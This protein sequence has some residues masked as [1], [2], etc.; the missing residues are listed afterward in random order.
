MLRWFRLSLAFLWTLVFFALC[1]LIALFRPFHHN[2][3]FLASRILT[4]VGLPILGIKVQKMPSQKTPDIHSSVIIL[5]H[6]HLIDIFVIGAVLPPYTVMIGKKELSYVPFLGLAF[7]LTGNIFINRTNKTKALA[8]IKK[9]KQL[10]NQQGQN[11]LIMP[12]GTRSNGRGLLPFKKG[13]FHLA[14]QTQAPIQP[15]VTSDYYGRLDFNAWSAGTIKFTM[16]D[17]IPTQGLT[18]QDVP[19]IR[20]L[21]YQRMQ[22]KITQFKES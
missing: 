5:N 3:S 15:I 21:A 16:I 20:E 22:A 8:S 19:R 14:I 1:P 7:R 9:A 12:E 13:P 6:Q 18:A 4:C 17:V 2:N 10:L 11:I